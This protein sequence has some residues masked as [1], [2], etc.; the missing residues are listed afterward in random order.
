M[1]FANTLQLEAARRR[2]VPYISFNYDVH[3][4]FQVAQPIRCR[5]RAF[6]TAYTLR[7]PV[8]FNF[9]PVSLTFDLEHLQRAGCAMIKRC[10]KF[11]RN[12]TIRGGV[13]AV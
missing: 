6:F 12:R 8:T 13:I 7:Y 4:K 11:Q 9:D 1:A 5:L 10:T 2:A 3:A